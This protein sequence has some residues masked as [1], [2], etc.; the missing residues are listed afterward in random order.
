MIRR[1]AGGAA[2]RRRAHFERVP[3]NPTAWLAC[4]L[5]SRQSRSGIASSEIRPRCKQVPMNCM[6][7]LSA[8]HACLT[9]SH[10]RNCAALQLQ[11]ATRFISLI[12]FARPPIVGS[13]PLHV[14]LTMQDPLQTTSRPAA[15]PRA[16]TAF[17]GEESFKQRVAGC[18][19]AV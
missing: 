4:N 7:E 19:A 12:R 10:M 9:M 18:A 16:A 11:S 1:R 3:S 17:S 2:S 14:P 6:H 5:G 15:S 8:T 13:A